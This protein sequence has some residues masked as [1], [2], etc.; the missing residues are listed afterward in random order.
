MEENYDLDSF[1]KIQTQQLLYQRDEAL[2]AKNPRFR[3]PVTQTQLLQLNQ[4]D[5]KSVMANETT[6]SLTADIR[7]TPA[8]RPVWSQG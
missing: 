4:L 8:D 2:E 3:V 5:V 7:G 6:R 1:M